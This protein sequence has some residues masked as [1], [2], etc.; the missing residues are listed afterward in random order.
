MSVAIV[1]VPFQADLLVKFFCNDHCFATTKL[2]L[3]GDIVS[4]FFRSSIIS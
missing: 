1:K 3:R 2:Q 4:P